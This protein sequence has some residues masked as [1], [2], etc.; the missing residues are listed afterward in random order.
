MIKKSFLLVLF[1]LVALTSSPVLGEGI[2]DNSLKIDS[3]RL[4]QEENVQRG[5]QSELTRSLF[6]ESDQKILDKIEK[7]HLEQF[8]SNQGQLF[9]ASQTKADVYS[10]NKLFLSQPENTAAKG[11][12]EDEE[13]VAVFEGAL[14][15]L[16]YLVAI[17]VMITLA[18]FLSYQVSKKGVEE[19]GATHQY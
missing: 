8:A 14:P 18:S 3:K 6:S 15:G 1:L 12:S 19:G 17:C 4:E 7:N 11:K 9:S 16:S 2:K 5:A 10:V 13:D